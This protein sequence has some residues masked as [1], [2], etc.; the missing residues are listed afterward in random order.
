MEISTKMKEPEFR[1]FQHNR[2]KDHV[3]LVKMKINTLHFST[4][5]RSRLTA[6]QTSKT[7]GT[8]ISAVNKPFDSPVG[9]SSG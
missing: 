7:T 9:A 2:L 8:V 3:H 6:A 4:A 1:V 5:R